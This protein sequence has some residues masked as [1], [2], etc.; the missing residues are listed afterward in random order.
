MSVLLSVNIDHVATLRN[1]RGGTLPDPVDAA[2]IAVKAGANGITV[3]LREDRRHIRDADAHQLYNVLTVPLNLEMACTEEMV[4]IACAMKPAKCTLVPERRQELTTEGGLDVLGQQAVLTDSIKRLRSAD[5]V[6]SLFVT[7]DLAQIEASHAVGANMV[8][9]H[10]GAYA[11]AP[12][13]A[14]RQVELDKLIAAGQ[15]TV[16][17]G[18]RLNAG[19]GLT[20]LNVGPVA[21]IP[22]MEELN[23]GHSI[24]ARA[25]MVGLTQAVQELMQAINVTD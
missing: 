19:H 12:T 2:I 21:A 10:T 5:I 8:E 4:A 18:M 9:L 16:K 1:A 24:M 22:H 25:I 3:H 14:I 17:L 11:D 20:T 7:A 23:I 15:L 13:D 6:V